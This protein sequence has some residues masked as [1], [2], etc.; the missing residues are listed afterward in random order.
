MQRMLK[1][2]FKLIPLDRLIH[3]QYLAVYG[4]EWLVGGAAPGS[5]GAGGS[6][7]SAAAAGGAGRG[8]LRSERE[9]GGCATGKL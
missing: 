7:G 8:C 4:G 9:A 3:F 6:A 5:V 1:Q 2:V